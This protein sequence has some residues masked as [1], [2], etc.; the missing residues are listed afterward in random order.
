MKLK[1]YIARFDEGLLSDDVNN[2]DEGYEGG[3]AGFDDGDDM[4]ETAIDGMPPG[5]AD[6]HSDGEQI[7][8]YT[9]ER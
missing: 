1:I 9:N 4:V 3:I 2:D 8:I 5:H 7:S 6:S